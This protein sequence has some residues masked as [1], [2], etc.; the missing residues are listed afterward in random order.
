MGGSFHVELLVITRGYHGFMENHGKIMG[1][2]WKN[3]ENVM[4]FSEPQRMCEQLLLFRVFIVFF[5]CF[6]FAFFLCLFSVFL[7]VLCVVAFL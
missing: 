6:D 1:T 7:H 2:C 5:W 3:M 4:R